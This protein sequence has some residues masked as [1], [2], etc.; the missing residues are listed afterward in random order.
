MSR[1]RRAALT[2]PRFSHP[3]RTF[4]PAEPGVATPRARGRRTRGTQASPGARPKPEPTPGPPW[5]CCC[6]TC[7]ETTI[8]IEEAA[9]GHAQREVAAPPATRA[10]GVASAA[11]T[12]TGRVRAATGRVRAA[13]GRAPDRTAPSPYPYPVPSK[14]F[15]EGTSSSKLRIQNGRRRLTKFLGSKVFSVVLPVLCAGLVSAGGLVRVDVVVALRMC[16]DQQA[17]GSC[18]GSSVGGRVLQQRGDVHQDR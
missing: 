14:A 1:T 10:A 15:E 9:A 7:T 17:P 2:S 11:R 4:A 8:A 12:S 6:W 18:L 16:Q 3:T 5:C 13:T